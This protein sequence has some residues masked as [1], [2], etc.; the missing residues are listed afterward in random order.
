MVDCWQTHWGGFARWSS[1]PRICPQLRYM[2]MHIMSITLFWNRCGVIRAESPLGPTS[3][4]G[5]TP[6]QNNSNAC[7]R[8]SWAVFVVELRKNGFEAGSFLVRPTPTHPVGPPGVTEL[9]GT[10]KKGFEKRTHKIIFKKGGPGK[11][12]GYPRRGGG[13]L[14]D[15]PTPPP[16]GGWDVPILK[17]SLV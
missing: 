3:L 16:P 10:S 7:V 11:V 4:V 9:R 6:A 15:P 2:V 13:W 8:N 1:A 14:G 12:P 5:G 17:R